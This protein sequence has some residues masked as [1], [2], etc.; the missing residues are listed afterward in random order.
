MADGTEVDIDAD[1]TACASPCVTVPGAKGELEYEA[2]FLSNGVTFKEAEFKAVVTIPV[3]NSLGIDAT[4][5]ATAGLV[6]IDLTRLNPTTQL[7]ES[8]ATCT[9]VL[10]KAKA[11]SLTYALKLSGKLKKGQFVVGK[12]LLG[13][14]D[15]DLVTAGVQ[16]GIP[17]IQNG[18]I[19]FVVV[20][21]TTDI[22]FASLENE[23]DDDQGEN[24][25]GQG[26][27]MQ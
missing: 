6:E 24:D 18:D 4:N 20:N 7:A 13:F 10:K 26:E 5:G 12:K 16:S 9:M 3:P 27:N 21:D 17:A 14:C 15:I 25:N 11:T 1:L 8:Y 2:Q 22:L 19:A 23:N